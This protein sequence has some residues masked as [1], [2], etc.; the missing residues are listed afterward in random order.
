MHH[1]KPPQKGD[2]SKIILTGK[3][4]YGIHN[5]TLRSWNEGAHLYIGSFCSIAKNQTVFL[6]GSHR[7]DWTT[8]FP[9]GHI[10]NNNFPAGRINGRHGHPAT[11]GHVIIEHDVW[12]GIGCTIMSGITIGTGSILAAQSVVVKDVEPYTIVGG[13][14][15]KPIKK[16]FSENII[17]KLLEI[18]WWDRSDEEINKIVPLLQTPPTEEILNQIDAILGQSKG[19]IP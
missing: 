19:T 2:K 16:R 14:P 18:N 1:I 4:S 17:C 9:F 13:N 5:I 3:H 6:G 7:S 11:K 8:T 15:A 12:I 10:Y